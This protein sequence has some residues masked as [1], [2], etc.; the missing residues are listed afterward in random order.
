MFGRLHLQPNFSNDS[1][2]A[3][4]ERDTMGAD[5]FEAHEAFLPISTVRIDDL[6][7]VI[8]QQGK[9]QM[10]FLDEV[11]MRFSRIC[12]HA[13]KDSASL[14]ELGVFITKGAR[15]FGAT[16]S[17]IFGVEVENDVFASK[18]GQG[19]NSAVTGC[20]GKIGREIAFLQ[21]HLNWLAHTVSF[22]EQNSCPRDPGKAR[23][24]LT[25]PSGIWFRTGSRM[26]AQLARS[27][28]YI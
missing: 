17:R 6:L 28:P 20:S 7:V 22:Q 5:I 15:F 3:D 4:K 26:C 27:I 25:W 21:F 9:R 18:T 11:C 13:Q 1:L 16:G 19:N 24:A 12:A 14:F 10:V 23:S 8:Q 2:R